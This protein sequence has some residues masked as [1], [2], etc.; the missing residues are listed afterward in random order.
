[1]STYYKNVLFDISYLSH[2]IDKLIE[3][4]SSIKKKVGFGENK[5]EI[6]ICNPSS[7]SWHMVTYPSLNLVLYIF[8]NS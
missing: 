5:P 2:I 4:S 1:M 7:S 3:N 6:D 8:Y